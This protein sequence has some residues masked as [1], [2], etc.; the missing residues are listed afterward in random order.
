MKSILSI[1][2][3]I[4]V[5]WAFEWIHPGTLNN[6][7]EL[8]FVKKQVGANAQPWTRQFEQMVVTESLDEPANPEE[9]IDA[10][11]GENS[12]DNARRA[13]GNAL[14][15]Y[16]SGNEK[17]AQNAIAILNAWS[18]LKGIAAANQQKLLQAAWTGALFGPA[19]DIMLAYPK[20]L[21]ADI[22]RLRSMFRRVYYPLL[23]TAST[24][25]GNVDLTQIE[26]LLA[27]AVFNEDGEKFMRGMD[28]LKTRVPMYFYLESDPLPDVEKWA[29]P[30]KWINGLTQETCRDNGHHSQFGL[31]AAIGAAEIAWHQG[32]DIYSIYQ[33]RFVTAMELLAL[34]STS[35]NMQNVCGN[36]TT[37]SD[38]YDT[39]EIAYHHYHVRK[40][41]DLPNTWKMITQKVRSARNGPK[42]WNIFYETLTHADLPGK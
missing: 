34:Q 2:T 14:A 36:N 11:A 26:A 24:W 4:H 31:S 28:R 15:W 7:D 29:N 16:I 40:G 25:N 19:A 3:L 8:D 21:P 22:A 6:K 38:V 30:M 1:F 9:M 33:E 10:S 20:W 5:S 18:N 42:D 13:Y 32:M 37:T 41:V 23:N 39:W 27:I 17:Y 35:G 12:R